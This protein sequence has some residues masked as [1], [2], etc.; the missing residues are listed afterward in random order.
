MNLFLCFLPRK[1]PQVRHLS[2]LTIYTFRAFD[3]VGC[4]VGDVFGL[5]SFLMHFGLPFGSL[6]I[7]VGPVCRNQKSYQPANPPASQPASQPTRQPASQPANQ[8]G[9]CVL[10]KENL[11]FSSFQ[12]R[13]RVRGLL[14][15]SCL[16][17]WLRRPSCIGVVV[18]PFYLNFFESC[19]GKTY[20]R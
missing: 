8:T 1:Y 6:L 3:F 15:T 5:S 11:P 13:P 20:I 16:L 12:R 2:F 7:F 10:Y 18:W 9:A 4:S 14:Q 19:L 17:F